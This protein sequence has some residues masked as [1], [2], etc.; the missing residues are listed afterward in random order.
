VVEFLNRVMDLQVAAIDACGGDVDKMI[1]DAVL[2]RFQGED[3]EARAIQAARRV[4]AEI[5]AGGYKRQVG[6]G[7]FTGEVISGAVGGERRMDFPVIGDSVNIAA[8]LCSAAAA[9]ELVTDTGTL[10][11]A[12]TDEGFGAEEEISVKG[13]RD[14]LRFRRWSLT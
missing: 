9:G 13:R 2:A 4:L 7:I 11:A 1:G 8:R 3:A 5:A 10:G 6:I 14:A 12:G